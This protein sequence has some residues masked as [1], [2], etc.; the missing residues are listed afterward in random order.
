MTR[1]LT[2]HISGADAGMKIEEYLKQLGQ[3]HCHHVLTHLKRTE[4][5]IVLNGAWAYASQRL[6][7]G[8]LLQ[9]HITEEACSEQIVPV[10]LL[11]L[12]P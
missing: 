1:D 5:G 8:D 4:H 9:L 11:V 7:E 6:S 12:Y 3:F 10:R 2:Y